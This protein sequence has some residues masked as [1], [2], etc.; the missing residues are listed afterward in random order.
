MTKRSSTS[1]VWTI[2]NHEYLTKIRT[3]GFIIG[4]LLGP[5]VLLAF[6]FIPVIVTMLSSES[7]AKKIAIIDNTGKL[8]QAIVDEDTSKYFITNLSENELRDGVLKDKYDGYLV[9]PEDFL[10]KGEATVYTKGGGGLG[11]I[12]ALKSNVRDVTRKER[13]LDAGVDLNVINVINRGIEIQTEKITKEGTEKDYTEVYAIVGYVFGLIIYTLMI[14]YGQ[15]VSRGVIEEKANRIIEVIASSA[16]P[17]E[18]MMGK[19]IGIG[20]VGLTQ[21]LCWVVMSVVLLYLIGPMIGNMVS[22]SHIAQMSNQMGNASRQMAL[23]SGFEIPAISPW[24]FIAFI[25]Y[26]LSGYFLYA[27]LFAAI[28]SAVDQE[29]DAQ[30]LQLPVMLPIILPILFIGSVISNPDGMLSV[31]LSL[32]PFF[33]PILMMVRVAAT[34]VPLWQVA[35]SV[36]LMV[37]TFFACIWLASRI[38]RVGILMY[39]K[40]PSLKDLVKWVRLSG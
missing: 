24:V 25:F 8:G 34:P 19:V 1:K 32:I 6:I 36:V 23:P 4:T 40:K 37:G 38:Y 17:F 20:A 16:R 29:S 18:I 15:F 31:I 27:T 3:K 10:Q 21:V 5:L 35:L 33:T 13:L 30:Q 11:F 12:S 28:G 2:I 39:G 14:L 7:T 9:I 26:F 22:G